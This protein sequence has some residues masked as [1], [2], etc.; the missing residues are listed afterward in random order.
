MWT[1][2]QRR[3]L[4][5]LLFALATYLGFRYWLNPRYVPDV[6]VSAGE[7]ASELLDRIDP[8]TADATTLAAIPGVG[9]GLAGR[10]VEYRDQFQ[11]DRRPGAPFDRPEDLL[12]VRGIGVSMLESLKPYLIFRTDRGAAAK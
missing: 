2:S 8:N 1:P 12:K 9:E 3:V 4:I 6:P 11:R 7:R 5:G 10:I